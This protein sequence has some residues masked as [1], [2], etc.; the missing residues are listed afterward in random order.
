M[1]LNITYI[2]SAYLIGSLSAAIIVCRLLGLEDPREGGSKNP[3]ATNVLR[4]HGKTAGILSLTGDLL[5]GV[6]PVLVARYSGTP[7]EVIALSGLAVFLGHL[8]PVFFKFQGGKGVATSLGVLL[9]TSWLLGLSFMMTWLTVASISRYSSLAGMTAALCSAIFALWLTS[10][11]AYPI[12]FL[13]MAIFLIT[14]HQQ[15][16]TRLLAGTESKIGQ[17]KE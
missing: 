1:V 12:V 8:Y 5:K 16:I 15:N 13:I 4:L 3:G 9:A 6:I 7:D 2:F 10:N 11:I 17:K 14:R